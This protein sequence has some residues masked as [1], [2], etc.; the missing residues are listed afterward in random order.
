MT[1]R[2]DL[3][4]C[5]DTKPQP[6]DEWLK[7][8]KH[9]SGR[10]CMACD[11]PPDAHAEIDRAHEANT[12]GRAQVTLEAMANRLRDVYGYAGTPSALRLHCKNHLGHTWNSRA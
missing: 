6:F 12:S 4:I 1:K 9:L 8:Q 11:L 3:A 7:I 2:R 10:R 5:A